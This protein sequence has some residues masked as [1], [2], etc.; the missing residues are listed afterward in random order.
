MSIGNALVVNMFSESGGS[1]NSGKV[2][3]S[4]SDSRRVESK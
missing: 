3:S 1:V 2:E 4:R